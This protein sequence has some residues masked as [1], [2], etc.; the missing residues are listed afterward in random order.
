MW[1]VRTFQWKGIWKLEYEFWILNLN[2]KFWISFKI[3]INASLRNIIKECGNS[4]NYN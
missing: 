1:C 3:S 2:F 4:L